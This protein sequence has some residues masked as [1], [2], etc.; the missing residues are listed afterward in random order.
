MELVYTALKTYIFCY[1]DIHLSLQQRVF[2]AIA[3]SPCLTIET[4]VCHYSNLHSNKFSKQA[5]D[6]CLQYLIELLSKL[7]LLFKRVR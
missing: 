3:M 6:H 1:H 4:L 5:M 2:V 7:Y